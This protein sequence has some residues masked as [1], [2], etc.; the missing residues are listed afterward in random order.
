M[1]LVIIACLLS[2]CARPAQVVI[3]SKKFTESVLLGELLRLELERDGVAAEHRRELGGSRVLFEALLRGDIDVYP[4]YTGTV[5]AELVPKAHSDAEAEALLAERGL[6]VG[7]RLGFSDT[8]ALAMSRARAAALGITTIS[9]LAAHPEL[10]YGFSDEFLRRKD[11]WPALQERYGL[12]TRE[13]RGM[14]HDLAYRGLAAGALDVVDLYSTDAEARSDKLRVLVDDR[15]QFPDYRALYLCRADLFTRVP[16]ARQ[17]LTALAGR[18]DEA[19]MATMNARAKLDR[20]PETQVAADY[21]AI[22]NS[23]PRAS[24]ARRVLDRTREH[25]ALAM[26]SLIAA[27]GV[28]LPLGI[29]A[30]RRPRLGG[31]ILALV[32]VVQTI[33]SLALLVVMIPL[34]GIGVM[35]ALAALFLYGLLPIVRNTY[36]GLRDL[37]PGLIESADA[38]GLSSWQRLR[39]VE[40]PMASRAILGGI[41]TAAVINVG[42]AT[43]GALVGAGGYGQP[44]LSGIRLASTPLILEGAI[45]AALLAIAVEGAFDLAEYL[46][47]PRGL[48]VD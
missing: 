33:P 16:A 28:A 21:L 43:L 42:A 37:P 15:H 34:L 38:L 32:G 2:S 41:K 35:P 13:A 23:T 18:V 40:L 31:Y 48:R 22:D 1:R 6:V 19:E 9:D 44:I 4:E 11:G 12:H 47:V 14:D 27:I 46:L 3:G 39:L 7:A 26:L 45:P 17:A 36:V 25:L 5:R 29:L 8:Y 10:R 20:V 24:L 30:A